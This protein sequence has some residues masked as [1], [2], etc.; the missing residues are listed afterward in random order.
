MAKASAATQPGTGPESAGRPRHQIPG[1]A[2]QA[3]RSALGQRLVAAVLFGSR[4]RGHAHDA[5][6]WDLLVIAEQLPER[7]FERHLFLKR[8]LPA[9]CRGAVSML[10]KTPTEFESRVPSLYLDIAL[11]GQILYDPQ[12]YAAARLAALR[13]LI[14]EAGLYRERT[15]AGDAW[16]WRTP[17]AQPWRL[18]WSV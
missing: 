12:G 1:Q 8:V 16:R 6:D 2:V 7:A 5:S 15:A 14:Q 3:L 11:D 17:P 4:A 18:D 9:S 13:R 10:A